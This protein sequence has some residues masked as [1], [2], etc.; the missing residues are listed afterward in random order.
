MSCNG[1][2]FLTDLPG[3]RCVDLPM[4]LIELKTAWLA[5]LLLAAGCASH[6]ASTDAP[7]DTVP[8][9]LI[10]ID[11]MRSDYLQRGLSPHLQAMIE[12]GV[13]AQWMN[14][15]YPSLTFPNHYTLVTG[16][17]PDHHGIINNTMLDAELGAFSLDNRDAVGDGRWWS[18]EPIWVG[19]EKAGLPTATMFWPGSEAQIQGVRPHYWF[20]YDKNFAPQQRVRQVLDWL[21][22][23]ASTRP[24]LITLYFEDVDTQGHEH[25]PDSPQVDAAITEVDDAIGQLTQ[26]LQQ[27]GQ[28]DKVNIIVVSDHGM[29]NTSIE[30]TIAVEDLVPASDAKAI[31]TGQVV[32][33]TPLPGREQATAEQLLSAHAHVQCWRAHE[34]PERWHAGSHP[35]VPPFVCQADEGWLLY[36]RAVIEQKRQ[37]GW[38]GGGSHG[39]DPDLVS[40]RAI[41]IAQGPAFREN[42]S[43][44]PFDNVDVY[45]LLAR[46]L[47]IEPAR[48]DGDPRI[49]LPA[50]KD[51]ATSSTTAH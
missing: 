45:P 49:L 15:S 37:A 21:A 42:A 38:T 47:G 43:L 46:L 17:R 25:G 2:V 30:R 44:A 18:G 26:V 10:S 50:L 33:L 31:S 32:G 22:M 29:A 27:R 14:P 36:S 8:L 5:L 11:G 9:L 13:H 39:Y 16:L 28:L 4:H 6:P 40:M 41:F 12:G 1:D 3:S 48:N 7:N 35:R 34:L 23:P 51:S 19:A 24:R 20:R